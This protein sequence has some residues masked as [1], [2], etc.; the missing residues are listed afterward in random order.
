MAQDTDGF[1]YHKYQVLIGDKWKTIDLSH[2]FSSQIKGMTGYRI[3]D[4]NGKVVKELY[5][6]YQ[7]K[8]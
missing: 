6:P 8:S 3:F 7:R 4:R 2:P 1:V 5:S